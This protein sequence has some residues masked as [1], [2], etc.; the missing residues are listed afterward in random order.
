MPEHRD[1]RLLER[2]REL[3]R[4]LAAERDDHAGELAVT[5]GA[6]RERVA[7]VADPFDGERLEE[8]PVARVVVGGDRLGVA[9]D[10]HGLEAGVRQRERGVD[11]AVVELDALPDPVRAAPEDHDRRTG[12]RRDLVL[13]LVGAVVV[14]RA[15]LELRRAGVDGL[16]GD[17]DAR[18]EPRLAHGV[19][20]GVPERGELR[21]AEPEPLRAPPVRLRERGDGSRAPAA[22]PAP[23]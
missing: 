5:L 6:G 22:G 11:A 20:V 8:E 19:R 18:R 15:R 3:Q 7:D 10:H 9:V 4:R 21:V 17:R 13:V 12:A 16:V 14:R 2:V 23:R 1:A